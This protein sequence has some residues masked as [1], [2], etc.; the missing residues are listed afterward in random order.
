MLP[1][2]SFNSCMM[3]FCDCFQLWKK[4]KIAWHQVR[5]ERSTS[6]KRQAVFSKKIVDDNGRMSRSIVMVEQKIFLFSTCLAAFLSQLHEVDVK[7]P[8]VPFLNSL[9]FWCIFTIHNA[10]KIKKISQNLCFIS[11]F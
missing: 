2:S 3:W 10:T 5:R 7:C 6:N 4:P 11:S 9:A 1:S 8:G